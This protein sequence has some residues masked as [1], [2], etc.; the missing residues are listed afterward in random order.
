[1]KHIRDL[2]VGFALGSAALFTLVTLMA[3]TA[4]LVERVSIETRIQHAAAR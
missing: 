3:A 2:L 4:T 1:M